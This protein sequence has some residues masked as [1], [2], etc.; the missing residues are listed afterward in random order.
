MLPNMVNAA[1]MLFWRRTNPFM[2]L[3][4][5]P[6]D[7][8]LEFAVTALSHGAVTLRIRE[9]NYEKDANDVHLGAL[10][11]SEHRSHFG[12]CGGAVRRHRGRL[13]A[14]GNGD[15]PNR[16]CGN[17]PSGGG[18]HDGCHCRPFELILE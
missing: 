11:F 3:L 10:G 5:G 15:S 14:Q 1:L 2:G 6:I 17:L 4:F 12:A 16:S 8:V 9:E 7:R 18:V 13:A